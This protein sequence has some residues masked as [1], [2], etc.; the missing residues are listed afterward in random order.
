VKDK[1]ET[2]YGEFGRRIA[3]F[4]RRSYLIHKEHNPNLSD[5]SLR[6]IVANLS[7]GYIYGVTSLGIISEPTFNALVELVKETLVKMPIDPE[8]EEDK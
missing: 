2:M 8:P 6:G 3:E 7:I 4:Y 5:E 1:L